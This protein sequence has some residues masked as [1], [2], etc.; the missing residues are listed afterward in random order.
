MRSATRQQK[1]MSDQDRKRLLKLERRLGE[2]QDSDDF[3]LIRQLMADIE[4]LLAKYRSND[5]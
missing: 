2:L 5:P 3:K 4:K 1:T